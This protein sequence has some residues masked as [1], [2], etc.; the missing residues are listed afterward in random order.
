MEYFQT[1]CSNFLDN[2]DLTIIIVQPAVTRVELSENAEKWCASLFTEIMEWWADIKRN[3]FQ[4]ALL[5]IQTNNNNIKKTKFC[6][7]RWKQRDKAKSCAWLGLS[8]LKGL[9]ETKD[10]P[11]LWFPCPLTWKKTWRWGVMRWTK[12][13]TWGTKINYWFTT[14]MLKAK[15]HYVTWPLTGVCN[16]TK[17]EEHPNKN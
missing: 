8:G 17:T 9:H 7:G 11:F 4:T 2:Y 1:Y 5:K 3:I 14:R 12:T 16:P 6:L 15:G 13:Q 10:F